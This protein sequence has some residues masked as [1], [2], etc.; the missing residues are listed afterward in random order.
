MSERTEDPDRLAD[1][2]EQEADKLGRHSQELQEEIEGTRQD[3]ERKRADDGV[4]GAVPRPAD[5][6][7]ESGDDS[8]PGET[9]AGPDQEE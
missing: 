1:Q 7:A 4:P 9:G 6:T 5:E 8:P 3:W 2:L